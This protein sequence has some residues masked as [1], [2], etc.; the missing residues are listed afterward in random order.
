MVYYLFLDE[1]PNKADSEEICKTY[2]EKICVSLP[3]FRKNKSDKIRKASARLTNAL[4]YFLFDYALK[5]EYPDI[6]K[7]KGCY[8]FSNFDYNE[9]GKPSLPAPYQNIHFNISH[10]NGAVACIVDD[11]EVGVDIQDV[12]PVSERVLKKYDLPDCT[13]INY[14]TNNCDSYNCDSYDCDNYDC[15]NHSNDKINLFFKFWTRFEA[16]C[17][18]TGEGIGKN[19]NIKPDIFLAPKIPYPLPCDS[20]H[21]NKASDAVKDNTVNNTINNTVNNTINNIQ[22]NSFSSRITEISLATKKISSEKNMA[23]YYMSA[24]TLSDKSVNFIEVSLH[25]LLSSYSFC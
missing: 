5:T 16:Y 18:L 21:N 2:Y 1:F 20:F 24:A 23:A 13:T 10:A 6:F 12:R 25:S 17:K 14:N 22:T 3:E 8:P 9:Y 19:M 11:H 7:Q 15:D 4:A